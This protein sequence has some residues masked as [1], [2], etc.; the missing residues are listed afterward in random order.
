MFIHT[1]QPLIAL[2]YI[3]KVPIFCQI[4]DESALSRNFLHDGRVRVKKR[5]LAK[6]VNFYCIIYHQRNKTKFPIFG[7]SPKIF[8]KVRCPS[9]NLDAL[10]IAFWN[11]L[12][13][14]K[15]ENLRK[16]S[17]PDLVWFIMA[18]IES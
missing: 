17:D 1:N 8:R 15:T 9:L 3:K 5:K 7:T 12:W 13:S 6:A 16:F 10:I 11:F 4:S 2:L 18:N 14:G